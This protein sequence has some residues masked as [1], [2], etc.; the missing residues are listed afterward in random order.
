VATAA[1]YAAGRSTAAERNVLRTGHHR[2]VHRRTHTAAR[3]NV[4][5]TATAAPCDVGRPG[6]APL[7]S[8]TGPGLLPPSCAGYGMVVLRGRSA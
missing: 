7:P 8:G 6:R 3:R 2:S 1:A 4:L 5:R